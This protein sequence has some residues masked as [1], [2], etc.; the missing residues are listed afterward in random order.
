MGRGGRDE[1]VAGRITSVPH[2]RAIA[3]RRVP[4]PVRGYVEGGAGNECTLGANVAAVQAVR[5]RPR[6]GEASGAPP[7]LST[8]VLGT[9]VSMPVLL[10]PIGFTRMMHPDGDV[11]GALAASGAGTI[12]TH[13][14]MS[15][16]TMEQ[17]VGA[18]SAPTWF[19]L[20]FL[21]GRD[22]AARLVGRARELG[23]SGLVVTLDTA[24]PGDRRRES[25]YRLSPPLRLD[26]Q[27]VQRMAPYALL[28]PR[29][30]ADAARDGFFL[31][32]V[33]AQ[34]HTRGGTPMGEQEALIR[35]LGEP[36]TW[37][38]IGWIAER[39]GGPVIAKGIMTVDDARR[40]VEVGAS[41]LVVSN[42]GG[43][44]LDGAPAT[45]AVL[46]QVVDAVGSEIEVLVDGGIRSGADVVR[47]VALGARA[48]LVGRAWAYGLCAAGRPGVDQVLALLRQDIDRTMR[49]LGVASIDELDRSLVDGPDVWPR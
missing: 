8:T 36:A 45:F 5:F 10:G 33:N 13:S 43:R 27:T 46:E 21:G 41:A 26:R 48:A 29:W 9:P 32:L 3:S 22:G 4:A 6:V 23:Y 14:S 37:D 15:G 35:W 44:Q 30:L 47:A 31:D 49:L 34:G 40:A 39:F 42:H 38:D 7:D 24:I 1:R 18:A 12:F 25:R 17:V 28:R 2:A 11:A 19:Q 16:H 20:Y